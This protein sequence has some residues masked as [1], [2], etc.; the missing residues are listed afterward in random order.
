MLM[1]PVHSAL[2]FFLDDGLPTYKSWLNLQKLGVEL[3]LLKP[4]NVGPNLLYASEDQKCKE[5]QDDL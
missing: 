4:K 3:P 1:V 5:K 2:A